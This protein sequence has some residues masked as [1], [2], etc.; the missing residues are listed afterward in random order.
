[1]LTADLVNARRRG[2]ELHL[3]S[4]DAP[5]RAR[6]SAMAAAFLAIASGHVGRTR[7]ELVA[8]LEA[9]EVGPREHR[10]KAGLAKLIEDRCA[11]DAPEDLDPPAVRRDVFTTASAARAALEAFDRFDR[12]AILAEIALARGTTAVAIERALFADLRGAHVLVAF[13]APTADAFVAAYEHAQ[14]QAVLLRAVKVTVD[15]RCASP[16][17]LRAFF[18]KLKFLRLLHT[19]AKHGKQGGHRIVIDGPFSLFESVTKYGLQL[20][21]VLPALEQ[22]DDW[23]LEADVRW[24]KERAPLVFRLAGKASP[25]RVSAPPLPDEVDALARSFEALGTPWR[26]APN[27][28]ILEL[29]GI[30]LSVPDLV[31]ERG[32][33]GARRE[34]VYLEVMG[35]WSRAAV[36]KRVELVRAGLAE[37]IL[38]AVSSRLRVSEEV[39][40]D[41]L[42]GALYVYKHTISARTIAQRLESARFLRWFPERRLAFADGDG[43]S[44]LVGPLGGGASR[45]RFERVQY[46]RQ[47]ASRA[48]RAGWRRLEPV[49]GRLRL[50]RLERERRPRRRLGSAERLGGRRGLDWRPGRG[51]RDRADRRRG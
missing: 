32:R 41:E 48:I 44:H 45:H 9:I 12:D 21:L 23:R 51:R 29:P 27:T 20:A 4:F 33:R 42:P 6:A 10:L 28:D 8:A 39:L 37:R 24:G 16:G 15:V 14:A 31:F 11:F 5:A 30:G 2:G 19:I 40:D 47:R 25:G 7:E 35:Y 26:V 3:I 18:R 43:R 36:W 1:M 17:A 34:R 38:F 49:G 22:C 50:E 46:P 13:D